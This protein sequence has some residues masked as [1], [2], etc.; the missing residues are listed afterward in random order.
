MT[1]QLSVIIPLYNG[2]RTIG[3]LLESLALQEEAAEWEVVIADNGST[4]GGLA[5]VEDWRSRLPSLR[6]VDSSERSGTAHARNFGARAAHGSALVFIDHDDVVGAGYIAAMAA[7]LRSHQFVCARSDV[8]RLNPEWTWAL[9]PSGQS[10]G[11]M[12]WIYDFLPYAAGG[13]IGIKRSVFE[14]VGGFDESIHLADCCDLC[15]RVQLDTPV[16]LTFAPEA[17]L[18]YRYRHSLRGMFAQARGYGRAEVGMYRRYRDRGVG[19]IP[20]RQSFGR[21][22]RIVRRL[23]SLRH[24]TGRAWWFT[25][26]GNMIG[27]LEGSVADRTLML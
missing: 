15:W 20:L 10:D 4:D 24:R 7:A 17:V 8:E 27:R 3:P 6:V 26:F 22:V 14:A 5:I 11:P 21:W 2:E 23:P 1:A 12:M 19:R 9:R 18:H 16:E 25:E 13:T